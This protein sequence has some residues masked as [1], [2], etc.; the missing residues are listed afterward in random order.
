MLGQP[1]TTREVPLVNAERKCE[2]HASYA[3][4]GSGALAAPGSNKPERTGLEAGVRDKS[5]GTELEG[6]EHKPRKPTEVKSE[7]EV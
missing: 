5:D 4:K 3:G 6:G 2:Y 1:S 7:S